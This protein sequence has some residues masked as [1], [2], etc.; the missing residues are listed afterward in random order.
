MAELHQIL[1]LTLVCVWLGVLDV[2]GKLCKDVHA[3]CVGLWVSCAELDVPAKRRKAKSAQVRSGVCAQFAQKICTRMTVSVRTV[4]G[5]TSTKSCSDTD[6]CVHTKNS[7]S[8]A[9]SYEILPRKRESTHLG[10]QRT[11]S[12]NSSILLTSVL[13]SP[14]KVMKGGCVPGAKFWR[15]AG[16]LQLKESQFSLSQRT[17]PQRRVRRLNALSRRERGRPIASSLY[18]HR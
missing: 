15:S 3:G 7:A 1:E 8:A 17:Q 18:R 13:T 5:Q 11:S 14:L 10:G 2:R 6:A 12:R 9:E 16:F 4:G